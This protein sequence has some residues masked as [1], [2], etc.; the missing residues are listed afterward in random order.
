MDE[1]V[2]SKPNSQRNTAFVLHFSEG[3]GLKSNFTEITEEGTEATGKGS[4][5]LR[6]RLAG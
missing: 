4:W 2:L 1:E 3:E 6:V 5:F